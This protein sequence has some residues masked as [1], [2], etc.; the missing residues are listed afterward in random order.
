M[1]ALL[2]YEFIASLVILAILIVFSLNL[3]T[4]GD[5]GDSI[6]LLPVFALC[7]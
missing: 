3:N 4:T 2:K 5:A 7:I 1:K 6:T